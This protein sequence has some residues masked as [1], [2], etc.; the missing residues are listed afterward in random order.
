M[1]RNILLAF[2]LFW[3]SG[4]LGQV[5]VISS[6][7]PTSGKIGIPVTITGSNFDPI[8][9]KN[10][11]YFGAVRATVTGATDTSLNVIVPVGA[12]YEPI[13][14]TT[15]RLIGY[16][17]APFIVTFRANRIVN[18]SYFAAPIGFATGT[19]W[20]I[21]IG[22][23]DGDGK[24]DIASIGHV[25]TNRISVL[26]NT[27]TPG[28]IDT[29]SFARLDFPVGTEHY[30]IAIGDLNGDGKLDLAVSNRS[31]STVSVLR[32]ASTN[33]RIRFLETV[34]FGADRGQGG[35][36]IGDL[37]GDGKLDLAVANNYPS[38]SGVSV[39]RNT[40]VSIDTLSFAPRVFFPVNFEDGALAV[41]IQDLNGDGRPDLVVTGGDD[42]DAYILRNWSTSGSISFGLELSVS[43]TGEFPGVAMGDLDGDGRPDIALSSS[44]EVVDGRVSVFRNTSTAAG[45][46]FN[47]RVD[48][49][50]GVHAHRIEVGDLNGDGKPD[51]LFNTSEP[52]TVSVLPN[53]S[54]IGSIDTSS[55][56]EKVG[57]LAFSNWIL[58]PS[59]WALAIVDLN[60][61]GRPD[62][63]TGGISVLRN[64]GGIPNQV[65]LLSPEDRAIISSDTVL[66]VWQQSQPAVTRYRFE[67]ATDSMFT[68]PIV[69][70]T[71]T[72]TTKTVR[73]LIN[74]QTYWW[75]VRA[76]NVMG[77]GL[78]VK[79]AGSRF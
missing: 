26:R 2:L 68:D 45:I 41:A 33:G 53:T 73:Q 16:S 63:V 76:K 15:N 48:F 1:L 74:S 29:S 10:I 61:D 25:N 24:P 60:G 43:S 13:T 34:V 54:T 32:N 6:F 49:A 27:S 28:S 30:G 51:L 78:L 67:L 40:S 66:F 75:K 46:S 64:T 3:S 72:D 38:P 9:S 20:K 70:S 55:F 8:P 19:G 44:E 59:G 36:A 31:D 62:I 21:A 5:P 69:D 11:V 56:A 22:D 50:L 77:W 42:E 39:L 37:D 71:V 58:S 14:V 52:A 17:S 47:G 57:F 18:S 23:L 79:H 65:T 4:S 12:T 7:T 35:L